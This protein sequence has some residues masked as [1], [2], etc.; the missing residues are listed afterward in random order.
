MLSVQLLRIGTGYG[1]KSGIAIPNMSAH[2]TINGFLC[3]LSYHA[4]GYHAYHM[5]AQA[6]STASYATAAKPPSEATPS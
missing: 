2:G 4:L 5:S 6:P 1:G 3:T